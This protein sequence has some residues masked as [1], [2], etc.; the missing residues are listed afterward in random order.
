MTSALRD[1]SDGQWL[2]GL[3]LFIRQK[4]GGIGE[5]F[6]T[7]ATGA[8]GEL[9]GR[10]YYFRVKIGKD[11]ARSIKLFESLGFVKTEE[12]ANYFGEFELRDHGMNVKGVETLMAE[13]GV[14]RWKEVQLEGRSD[15]Q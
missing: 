11:N 1:R 3:L 7:S 15:G 8:T 9:Y 5:E 12:V 14:E 2:K 13:T 4:G 10:I 6:L